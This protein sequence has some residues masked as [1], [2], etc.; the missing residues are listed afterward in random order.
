MHRVGVQPDRKA[1]TQSSQRGLR[2]IGSGVIA[3]QDRRFVDNVWRKVADVV[4]VA[5]FAFSHRLA[6]QG[7]DGLRV[8]LAILNELLQPLSVDGGKAACQHC[9]LSDRGHLFSP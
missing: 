4:G 6:F 8:S 5:E 3:Q 2:R 9:F 7:L 1:R